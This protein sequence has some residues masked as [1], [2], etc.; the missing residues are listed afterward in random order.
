ML[1]GEAVVAI[2]NGI[3]PEGRAD[4]YA[5]HLHE[6]M[7]ERVGIAGFRRGRRYCALDAATQ[8]EFFTLYE[9]ETLQVLQGQDYTNRLNAPTPW[10]KQATQGFRDSSRG[11]AR[12]VESR[13]IGVGGIM[14]T[15]RFDAPPEARPAIATLVREAAEAP[16]VTGAHLCIA[17]AAASGV[18]TEEKKGRSDIGAPPAWIILAEATDAEAL[19]V[20]L[21]DAAIAAAGATGPLRRGTYRLEFQRTKT[22]WAS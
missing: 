18:V 3:T 8:P 2:W 9:A 17:D 5:W 7:A 6:H 20:L 15:L 14:L 13:G 10:T 19:A 12:V 16:R 1:A 22:A 21:P 11:L 4:F